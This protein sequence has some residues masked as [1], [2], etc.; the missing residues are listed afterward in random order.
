[1]DNAQREQLRWRLR[2][3]VRM[4]RFLLGVLVATIL[5]WTY[6]LVDILGWTIVFVPVGLYAIYVL[7]LIAQRLLRRLETWLGRGKDI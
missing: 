6:A 1:M 2:A 5:A 3:V 7:G 4:P